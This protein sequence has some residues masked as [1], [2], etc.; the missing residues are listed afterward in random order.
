MLLLSLIPA[1]V[2][3][4]GNKPLNIIYIMT[5]DHAQQTMSCY[6]GSLNQTPGLDRLAK[7]G[8]L[9]ENSFVTNSISGP[10]RAVLI[11]GKFSHL[12]GFRDNASTFD[13][14]QQTFP[15]L[16]QKAG[17]Q[18]A[19]IGK[20]HLV[21]QPTGFDYWTILPGQGSYYNP[22]FIT[23]NGKEKVEGY[24]TNI[25]TDKSIDWI[26]HRDKS[27]PFCLLLHHKAIHRNW[28]ADTTDLL[29]Y[30]DVTFR[31]P[32]T[33][34]DGYKNRKAAAY[35]QQSI[36]KD[37]DLTYDLKMLHDSIHTP[38]GTWYGEITRMNGSQ[39]AAWDRHY[40][41]LTEQFLHD[42]LSGRELV[43]WKFQRYLRDYL[44]CVK[45]V[46]DNTARLY[47]YLEKEGLLE[48]TI[49]VYASDQGFYMGEHGWFDKRFIYE[50]SLRT[51]LLV[52]MP[53]SMDVPRGVRVKQMVQNI[54]YAPTLLTLAGVE[55]PSDMQGCSLDAILRGQKVK[56]W[57]D[58]IYY[59]YY[60]YPDAHRV[61]RHYG[62]RTDRYKL[63][64]FYG[65][66][67]NSWEL[68]DLRTD[69]HEVN[70]VY[71]TA[72]YKNIQ[73]QL[74]Q[75]LTDLQAQYGDTEPEANYK[76]E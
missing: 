6:D 24:V 25:I 30:E 22:D 40:V 11:T 42:S 44:K 38:I 67:I 28:M 19:I 35:Q 16:L 68:F 27:K 29:A 70:N 21:S 17:Y 73:A 5:D 1:S 57:R 8:V 36:D 71:G 33:F 7:E 52:R 46:D 31:E 47:A 59:H 39:R 76:D 60:E 15:K 45:S 63:A 69:P 14:S 3:A 37:M 65:S 41:P 23:A 49:I 4:Q 12:N 74:H 10:S 20:W 58:A 26:E 50:E 56:T 66:D 61:H 34:W 18:T 43:Q 75:R 51:P 64:H 13:G 53:N 9:F 2:M 62:V 72:K 54:D 55:V 48:N 32:A